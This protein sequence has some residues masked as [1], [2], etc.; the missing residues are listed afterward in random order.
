MLKRMESINN[1][2]KMEVIEDICGIE[3]KREISYPFQEYA[4]STYS[5]HF[6]YKVNYKEMI[7]P[8]CTSHYKGLP[9]NGFT[10]WEGMNSCIECYGQ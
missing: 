3:G 1:G 6:S 5:W 4:G 9:E 8:S 7:L 10:F 2:K